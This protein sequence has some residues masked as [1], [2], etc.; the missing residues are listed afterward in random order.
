M[1]TLDEL[2]VRI[3]AD[4]SQLEREL[5]KVSGTTQ[6]ATSKMGA[7]LASVSRVGVLAFA[8]IG[9]GIVSFEKRA[10]AAADAL[11]DLSARSGVSAE[12]LSAMRTEIEN[13][14]GSIEQFAQSLFFMNR[15]IGE[16][17]S[18]NEAAADSFQRLGLNFAELVNQSPE[19]N[20]RTIAE[21]ISQLP[22]EFERAEASAALFGRGVAGLQPIIREGADGIDALMEKAQGF[23]RSLSQEQ[24]DAIDRFGD[25]LH[26]L[27]NTMEN[28][29][30]GGFANVILGVETFID[31]VREAHDEVRLLAAGG[32]D[33]LAYMEKAKAGGFATTIQRGTVIERQAYGPAQQRP[34]QASAE[35]RKATSE[36]KEM[37]RETEKLSAEMEKVE[38][39]A[40]VS[41]RVVKDSFGDALESA[42]FDVENFGDAF[43]TVLEGIARKIARRAWIDPLSSGFEDLIFGSSGARPSPDFIG[44]MMQGGGLL[45]SLGSFFG[46]FFADG[47]RP[48]VGKASIV[49]EDGPEWFIP[50]TAG[51]VVPNG[52]SMGGPSITIVQH[53]S[54]GS[55]VTRQ[56]VAAMLPAVKEQA[57]AGTLAAIENGGRAAQI[58]GKRA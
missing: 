3:K 23:G 16:A 27:G 36:I 28:L 33:A 51:T 40:I 14:G 17:M 25:G 53:N 43:D 32:L 41:A 4:A 50:D 46:G 1:A 11:N 6:Q 48:P 29:A 56:E 30:A 12:F 55:G 21:A 34:A 13:S 20:F 45:D 2:V 42:T 19:A 39:N 18:G 58:V 7:A 8:A 9:V 57:I 24:L 10:I 47:G 5:Q 15:Q 44:P 22:T 54:F 37:T 38:D 52:G 35:R 26:T 49:G 31:I